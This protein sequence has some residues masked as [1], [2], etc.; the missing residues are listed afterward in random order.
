[1]LGF[2]IFGLL[3]KGGNATFKAGDIIH[4]YIADGEEPAPAPLLISKQDVPH[5]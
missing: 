3:N 2:G 5:S 4:G 1:M